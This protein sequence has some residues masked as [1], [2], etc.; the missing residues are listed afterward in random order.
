MICSYM[1]CLQVLHLLAVVSLND[2]QQRL[3]LVFRGRK[4]EKT[5]EALQ[6]WILG[7]RVSSSQSSQLA[8][9]HLISSHLISSHSVPTLLL[10]TQL[11]QP[12]LHPSLSIGAL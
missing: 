10:T 8:L 12:N 11:P 1:G 9:P 2:E 5:C 4:R 6:S 3:G 7:Y